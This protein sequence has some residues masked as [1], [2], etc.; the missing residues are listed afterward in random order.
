MK[1]EPS[2]GIS[3]FIKRLK[4]TSIGPFHPFLRVRIQHFYS[5]EGRATTCHLESREIGS[6][7][8]TE[9]ANTLILNFVASRTG[10]KLIYVCYKLLIFLYNSRNGLRE[11][12]L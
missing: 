6:S 2:M 3:E 8:D 5:L 4:G 11:S 7:A 9:P 12:T 10:R 1:M